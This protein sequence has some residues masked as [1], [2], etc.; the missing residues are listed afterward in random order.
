[1]D[2]IVPGR[3]G[4]FR[5]TVLVDGMVAGMWQ[6][7]IGARGVRVEVSWFDPPAPAVAAA[8]DEQA[9]RYADY[10]GLPLL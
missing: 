2:D 8:A 9:Q 6:R 3:N 7:S 1:M 4:V 10:L 5:P